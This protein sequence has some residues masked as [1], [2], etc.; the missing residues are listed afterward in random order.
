MA[1]TTDP[2]VAMLAIWNTYFYGGQI[3]I[4]N[5]PTDVSLRSAGSDMPIRPHEA[6]V[7]DVRLTSDEWMN[8]TEKLF[9]YECDLH[10]YVRGPPTDINAPLMATMKKQRTA[11]NNMI[12]TIMETYPFRPVSDV[13]QIEAKKPP[14]DKDIR[15]QRE[16]ILHSIQTGMVWIIEVA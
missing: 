10:S 8:G 16:V 15:N 14:V 7:G 3:I 5:L 4:A 9:K 13:F 12:R 6:V 2:K 1:D 11:I